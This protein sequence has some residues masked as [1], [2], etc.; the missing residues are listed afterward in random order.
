MRRLVLSLALLTWLPKRPAGKARAHKISPDAIE[1]VLMF[2]PRAFALGL[3][4][5]LILL[6]SIVLAEGPHWASDP[7]WAVVPGKGI[8]DAR[9]GMPRAQVERALAEIPCPDWAFVADFDED[10]LSRIATACGGAVRLESG[11]Q[12][13]SA[14]NKVLRQFGPPDTALIVEDARYDGAIA[15]WMPY[16]IAGIAFRVI[17]Y[18]GEFTVQSIRVMPAVRTTADR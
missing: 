18:R 3:A 13:G 14:F 9:L 11:L 8:G 2:V 17:E 4:A 7:Y 10:H 6:P 12:V 15:Y 1:D 5:I 16:P